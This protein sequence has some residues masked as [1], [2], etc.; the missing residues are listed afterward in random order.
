MVEIFIN[1]SC[2]NSSSLVV[3]EVVKWLIIKYLFCLLVLF[4]VDN[5]SILEYECIMDRSMLIIIKC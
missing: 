1:I 4:F 3:N 2:F 5:N